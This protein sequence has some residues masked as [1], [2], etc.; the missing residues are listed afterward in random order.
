MN[1]LLFLI[2]FILIGGNMALSGCKGDGINKKPGGTEGTNKILEVPRI[3]FIEMAEPQP[4]E[5][6]PHTIWYDDF[7]TKKSYMDSKGGIDTK[8]NFGT[9]GG[10]MD[11]GFN[12]GDV[13]GRGNRKVAF[14]D[15][16]GNPPII[17]KGQQFN[18]IFWR[19]YVKHEHGWEGSP[20]KMSRATSIVSGNWQ[21]AMIAHVWSGSGNTL[22]LDPA[23]G[24]D[25]QTDQ[26]KTTRY[27]DFDNLAWLGNKP[28]SNFRISSTEESGYWVLVE[29]RV[30]LNTP[31]ENDGINQLWIDGRLEAER[32]N[33]NLRGSYTKHGIN[34][35]FLESYW[36][37]GSIKTQG[38]WFDNFVIST[39]FIGPVVC[40]ANPNLYKTPYY[41]PGGLAAWEVELASDYDGD[42][43]VFKSNVLGA[44]ENVTISQSNGSFSGSLVGEPALS[45]GKTYFCRVRQKS[46]NGEWSDWSRWHQGFVVE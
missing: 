38:R 13:N 19:I 36:N 43:V 23:R 27:N 5:D 16:P 42:D 2:G 4:H 33:L 28:N 17:N 46:S 37:S 21:Q 10:S 15:F 32:R 7:S 22:T 8:V 1:R 24:V 29:S 45:S 40:P 12:K 35:V 25:G 39:K 9:K 14:G 18:E 3:D 31:G 26:I 34:A 30:K 20:A 6:D 41:G 44:V 11:A